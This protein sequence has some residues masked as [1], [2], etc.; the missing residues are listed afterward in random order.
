MRETTLGPQDAI[1]HRHLFSPLR[2]GEAISLLRMIKSGA[3]SSRLQKFPKTHFYLYSLQS[4]S[5]YKGQPVLRDHIYLSVHKTSR[6]PAMNKRSV[7]STVKMSKKMWV[8]KMAVLV[9]RHI[10]A[11]G[12]WGQKAAQALFST[13][14]ANLTK[15]SLCLPPG[16]SLYCLSLTTAP[17][18]HFSTHS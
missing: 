16:L 15:P 13:A 10:R 14:Q 6:N 4:K 1:E 7:D 5:S 17:G 9:K 18:L 8:H 2:K 3:N 11:P 12:P